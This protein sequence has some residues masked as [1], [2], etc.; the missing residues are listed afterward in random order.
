MHLEKR[1]TFFEQINGVSIP[2]EATNTANNS[3]T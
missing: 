3:T 1:A 2:F